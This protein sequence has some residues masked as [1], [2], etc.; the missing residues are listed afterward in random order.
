MTFELW[1]SFTFAAGILL[2]TPGPTIL[3]VVSYALSIGR[4]EALAMVAGVGLGDFIAMS[5]SL[6]GLG[7]L[8]AAS[9]TAFIIM[10]WVGA[11][12]LAYMGI[13]MIMTARRATGTIEVISR[14]SA[15]AAFRDATI[16]T[17][18]NPK[19]IG[20]FI[21]FV[22]QFIAPDAPLAPQ[23]ATMLATFVGLGV[24]NALAYA[25][26][27]A[28][29]RDR[30]KTPHILLWMHRAGGAVLIGLALFTATLRRG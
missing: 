17:V 29:V 8:L 14:K 21:A 3:L 19:S 27:A 12:Y 20:F 1:L 24:L 22:P 11:A 5:L 30:I 18:L 28:H 10:K 7:A 13:R 15:G 16:V 6:I 9:A 4:I 23:F 2:I 25:L 26:L